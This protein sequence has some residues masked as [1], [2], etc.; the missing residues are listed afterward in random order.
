MVINGQQ[1]SW[2]DGSAVVSQC[3]N[4]G[5]L[6]FQLH[7]SNLS[8]GLKYNPKF[9]TGDIS[10]FAVFKDM[11]LPQNELNAELSEINNGNINGK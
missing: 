3:S 9:F 7:I 1:S 6:L 10:Q 4:L 5:P 2:E 8:E 11:N